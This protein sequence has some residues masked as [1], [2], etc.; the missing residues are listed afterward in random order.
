MLACTITSRSHLAGARVLAESLIEHHPGMSVVALALDGPSD[1]VGQDEP[2]EVLRP[3]DIGVERQE[4]GRRA[5]LYKPSELAWSFKAPLLR[6]LV[7][8]SGDSVVYLDADCVVYDDLGPLFEAV[9][10]H[11]LALTAHSLTPAPAVGYWA[12]ETFFQ[13]HGVFNS[14]VIGAG[15]AGRPFLDW[16]TERTARYC[17]VDPERGLT[18][19]QGW[20]TLVPALFDYTLVRDPGIN[21]MGW[22]LHDRDI[23]WQGDRPTLG[24]VPLRCFHFAGPFDPRQP[25][26]FRPIPEQREPWPPLAERP[27]AARLCEEYS[28]RVLAKGHLELLGARP[29]NDRTPGGIALDPLLRGLYRAALLDRLGID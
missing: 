18:G 14:G 23:E 13:R 9:P 17:E 11:G 6:H 12:T 28:R 24:G 19:D 27:G 26:D 22:S 21:V 8:R 15:P 20:L 16:W 3:E 10:A 2:F 5:L 1:P 29:I 4:L 25:D 7:E